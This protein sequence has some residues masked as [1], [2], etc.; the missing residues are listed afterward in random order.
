MIRLTTEEEYA[1]WQVRQECRRHIE[2][3]RMISRWRYWILRVLGFEFVYQFWLRG[4]GYG[5]QIMTEHYQEH[6]MPNR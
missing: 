4:A 3:T 2:E 5:I 1:T 6:R